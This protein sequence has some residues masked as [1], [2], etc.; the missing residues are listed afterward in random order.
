MVVSLFLKKLFHG[1]FM[2]SINVSQNI[3][4]VCYS[5]LDGNSVKILAFIF[6]QSVLK[7][8]SFF[9]QERENL[10]LRT[11]LLSILFAAIFS[12]GYYLFLVVDCHA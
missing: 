12:I 10:P 2:V 11:Y 3:S 8:A 9:G 4:I 5:A 6:V 7:A 1:L